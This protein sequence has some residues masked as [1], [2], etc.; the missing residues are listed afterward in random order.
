MPE[1]SKIYGFNADYLARLARQGKLQGKKIGGVWLTTPYDVE[2]F[3]RNRKKR[4]VYRDDIQ[5]D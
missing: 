4:G 5:A 3:I 1:A 2:E